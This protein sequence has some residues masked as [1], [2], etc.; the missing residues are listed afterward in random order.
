M[1]DSKTNRVGEFDFS[2]DILSLNVRGIRNYTK[3]NKIFN[4]LKNHTSNQAVVLLQE[5]HSTSDVENLSSN[6]WQFKEKIIFSNGEHN[7]RGTLIA[8]RENLV[9]KLEYKIIDDGGR[10]IIL[11]CIIQDSPILLV[12]LYNSNNEN[13]QVQIIEKVTLAIE[14]I[15]PNH[16]YN[17][18][19]GGDFNFIQDT[20]YDSDGGSPTLNKN[21]FHYRTIST[22]E[23]K[24]SC[25]YLAY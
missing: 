6:Q 14:N 20:V 15:D 13:E 11:K 18:V 10:Y 12:N 1:F 17:V 22:Q 8:F 9:Y 4:W 21:V 5:T 24:R 7:A 25:G 3:R 16:S 23:F 2:F 19:M